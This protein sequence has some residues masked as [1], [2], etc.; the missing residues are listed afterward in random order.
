MDINL[1]QLYKSRFL[2]YFSQ[3]ALKDILLIFNLIMTSQLK[4]L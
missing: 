3:G 4:Q 2:A 1:W